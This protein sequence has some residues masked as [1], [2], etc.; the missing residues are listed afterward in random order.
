MTLFLNI[1]YLIL[2]SFFF[3]YKIIG[4][5]FIFRNKKYKYCCNWLN[6]VWRNERAVEIPLALS[7]IH[8]CQKG[9]ILEVGN[10]LSQ[11]FPF[12]HDI[13]D[14][15]EKAEGVINEDIVNFKPKKNMI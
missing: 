13:V 1:K 7:E 10:V 2:R 6:M 14:K 12:K 4:P 9:N 8:S 15:Y 11:Y 3:L 5:S